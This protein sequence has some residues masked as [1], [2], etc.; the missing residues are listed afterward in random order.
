MIE[1]VQMAVRDTM[2]AFMAGSA[3]AEAQRAGIEHAKAHRPDSL[4]TSKKSRGF[5]ATNSSR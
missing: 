1:V 5:R 4:S 3:E 2:I